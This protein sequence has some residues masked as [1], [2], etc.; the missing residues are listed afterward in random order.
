MYVYRVLVAKLADREVELGTAAC[1]AATAAE[2]VASLEKCVHALQQSSAQA[3]VHS[4]EAQVRAASQLSGA[5]A[6][7][8][9]WEEE[10]ARIARELAVQHGESETAASALRVRLAGVEEGA[11][12]E[13]QQLHVRLSAQ[14]R[15]AEEE[16][17]TTQQRLEDALCAQQGV[18]MLLDQVN[19]CMY[20][21]I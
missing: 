11:R 2:E 12:V 8:R 19:M 9:N 6:L 10:A 1:A 14:V 20:V 3:H 7:A 18:R 21:Y 5:L 15:A 17:H 4:V 16:L 13:C